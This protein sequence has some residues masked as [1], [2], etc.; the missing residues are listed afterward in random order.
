MSEKKD[1]CKCKN[2]QCSIDK[3]NKSDKCNCQKEKG[4]K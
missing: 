4:K 3:N 1:K 2:G